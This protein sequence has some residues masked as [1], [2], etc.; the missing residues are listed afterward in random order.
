MKKKVFILVTL[1]LLLS[2]GFLFAETGLGAAFGYGRGNVSNVALSVDSDK[3]PGSVQSVSMRFNS[4]GFGLGITDD[5]YLFDDVF[6]DNP[7]GWYFGLGFYANMG[8]YNDFSFAFGARA[9]IGLDVSLLENQLVLFLEV[10]PS[11]GLGF[12][13][14]I[15]FPDW[16][17]AGALG[18]R[19]Y[20]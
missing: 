2:S 16:D 8:F 20:F 14:G 4:A 3:I 19:F 11:L 9:P 1:I 15:Y 7:F 5:W 6:I 13:P 12:D 10:A 17:I 18:F